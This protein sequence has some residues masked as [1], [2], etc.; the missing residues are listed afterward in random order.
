MGPEGITQLIHMPN[1]QEISINTGR[2]AKQAD[3]SVLLRCGDTV[4]LATVCSATEVAP[5]T[6]FFPLSVDYREKYYATGKFPGGFFKREAK[7]S[8]YEVLISRLI[9][10]ALRPLFPDD[11]HAET[12]VQ[13]N[14]LSAEPGVAPDALAALAASAAISVSDIPFHGPISEVRVALIG[15]EYVINPTFEQQEE[16]RLELMVAASMKDI[17]MVEGECKEVSEEEMLGALKAAHE[18]IKIQCAAQIELMEKVGKAKREYCHEVNDENIRAEVKEACYQACY[19]FALSGCA[20]KHLREDTFQGIL[21]KYLEKY[22]EEELETVAPLAK[23]YFH[24]VQRSAVRNAVLDKRTRLDGRQLT[25]VR[26]IW[27]EVDILPSAHGSAVF[28]RGETQA[29]VT[30]TLGTKLDEQTIDGAVVSGTKNFTLHYNFP[31]FATGEAKAARSTS[32]REIG[33]GNLAER[34][35]KSMVPHDETMPY[36]VRIVSDILESNGSS[37]MASVCGGCLALMDAGVPMRKP[38]AGVAMG[39]IS[40]SETGKYAILTDI[41]GDEDHIGDMDFKVTGT[42]DG[43]TACQMDIKVDGLSYEVLTEALEQAR[44]GRL[45]ILDEMAKTITEPRADYKEI[46]P[47]IEKLF[48][49][50]DFIGAVIGPGGKVIQEMQKETNTVISITEDEE[51]GIVEIASQNKA[52][53]EACK[54]KIRAII[55]VPEVGEVYHGK[56]VSIM[57]FG[58]FVEILPNKDGL[59]HISEIS[60]ERLGTMEE[61]GLKEGDEIDVKLI[62]I[63]QKT[64]KLR[65]SRRELLPKPEGYVEKKSN[66]PRPNGGNRNGGN[67]GEH[68]GEGHGNGGNRNN[69][70]N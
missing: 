43:I 61:S 31:G 41:L 59:L 8:D 56:V 63:D 14:L 66:G 6:D 65:L 25:Q 10:R 22:T 69:R 38:V 24:D 16:A 67:R 18:A 11:Y 15:D 27:T 29:M 1:G 33:H 28:T 12:I 3:G 47:R 5:E 42:R 44:Q 30:V 32:R 4:L 58:A 19:D 26:P 35:L 50:K 45:H 52:D 60:W 23:R 21:D 2:Y 70:R 62:E 53:I 20:D 54:A 17:C 39:M 7:P 49:P 64:G 46:V 37:S 68:R 13:V 9:D 34:A 55:A 48:I 57:A 40:D 51:K 36:T